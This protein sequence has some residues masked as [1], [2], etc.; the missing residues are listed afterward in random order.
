V[1]DVRTFLTGHGVDLYAKQSTKT[2]TA[3]SFFSAKA[4]ATRGPAAAP[5]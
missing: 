5:S 1:T 4:S 2:R 3:L